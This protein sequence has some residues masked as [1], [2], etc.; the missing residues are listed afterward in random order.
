MGWYCSVSWDTVMKKKKNNLYLGEAFTHEYIKVLMKKK[1]RV[2]WENMPWGSV[3]T[4]NTE[5]VVVYIHQQSSNYGK[6]N[7]WRILLPSSEID[8]ICVETTLIAPSQGLCIVGLLVQAQSCKEGD[9]Y[10]GWL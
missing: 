10:D 8:D 9:S 1:N 5:Y 2:L 3:V 4:M 7:W 6:H